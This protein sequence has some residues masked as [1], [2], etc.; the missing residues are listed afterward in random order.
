M[1][2]P[3]DEGS[4]HS[5]GVQVKVVLLHGNL[6]ICVKNVT[7]LPNMDS[8][9]EKFRMLLGTSDPYVTISVANAVIGRTY[10]VNNNDVIGSKLIGAVGI[11]A[12]ILVTDSVIE[13]TFPILNASGHPCKL[14]AI[15]TLSIQYTPVEKM[16]IYLDG[17]GSDLELIG[18]PGTYFPLRRGGKG[19][20]YQDAHVDGSVPSFKLDRGWSINHKVQLVRY[21]AKARDSILGELLKSKSEEGVRVLLLVWDDPTSKSILGYKTKYNKWVMQTHDE[22]TRVFFKYSKVQELLCPRSAIAGPRRLDY[23]VCLH[24]QFSENNWDVFRVVNIWWVAEFGFNLQDNETIY[25]HHQNSVIVD[26][27]AGIKRRITAFVG[28]LDLC[29]GR[30]DTPE[31]SLYSTLHMLHK[32]DYH[33]PNYTG[34]TVGCPREPWHDLHCR[35]EGPA[36]YDVLQ[37]FEERWLRASKPRGLSKMNRFSD[38]VLLK[39]DRIPDILGITDARYSSEKDPEGWHVQSNG[40][41]GMVMLTRGT[42]CSSN[43]STATSKVGGTGVADAGSGGSVNEEEQNQISLVA[44]LI[45]ALRKSM[46]A[47]R[48]ENENREDARGAGLCQM[49]IAWPTNVQH[50]THVTFDRFHGFLGRPVEFEV[51]IPCRVPSAS[52]SVFGVSAESMQ[53]SYDSRGNSVPTIYYFGYFLKSRLPAKCEPIHYINHLLHEIC[54]AIQSKSNLNYI[55]LSSIKRD[56]PSPMA[57][58]CLLT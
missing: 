18:V 37:N 54:L 34:S 43:T 12:G 35:I 58:L 44:L 51:K 31:H 56:P 55:C 4:Q 11:P 2:D 9:N 45:A 19:T 36:A 38:D 20:L 13:G 53:C 1:A 32:D 40:W 3:V 14:G 33:N 15:L 22:E 5:Q 41:V 26:A 16:A 49:E 23:N 29:R 39:V 24:L 46:V 28:G 42:G 48:V 7:H 10:V 57:P 27:D 52:V 50:L 21:G 8:F 47:C 6:D 25:T 30:Y 17:V